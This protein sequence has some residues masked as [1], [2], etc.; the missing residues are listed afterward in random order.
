MGGKNRTNP[1]MHMTL[2]KT[3]RDTVVTGDLGF[4]GAF[5]YSFADG[6]E[7]RY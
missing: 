5:E 4:I 3:L 7:S 1:Q 6:V 2:W